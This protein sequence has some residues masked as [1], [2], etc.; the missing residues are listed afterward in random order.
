MLPKLALNLLSLRDNTLEKMKFK[1]LLSGLLN[2]KV[3]VLFLAEKSMIVLVKSLVI[4]R[5]N[6]WSA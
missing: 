2:L 3:E 6:K 4:L 1:V 5:L